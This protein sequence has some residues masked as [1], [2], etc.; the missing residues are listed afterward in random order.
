M[1]CEALMLFVA[2]L[3]Q[4]VERGC[5]S[6]RKDDPWRIDAGSLTGGPNEQEW[7]WWGQREYWRTIDASKR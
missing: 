7:G 3:K 4:C 5:T 2:Y 6:A 1:R